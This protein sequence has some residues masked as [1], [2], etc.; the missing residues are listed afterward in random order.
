VFSLYR[1]WECYRTASKLCRSTA[2]PS[3]N[4]GS[5]LVEKG[6]RLESTR[7]PCDV[8]VQTQ[9]ELIQSAQF[10][11]ST[12]VQNWSTGLKSLSRYLPVLESID[13]KLSGGDKEQFGN[14]LVSSSHRNISQSKR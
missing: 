12:A 7:K 10:Y 4:D 8:K 3:V 14:L 11:F 2:F 1:P 13:T 5:M 6:V 9:A